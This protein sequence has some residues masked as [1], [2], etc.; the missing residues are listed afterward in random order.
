M[1]NSLILFGQQCLIQGRAVGLIYSWLL[2]AGGLI[3]V[4]IHS[5]FLW[6]GD[7]AFRL[8]VSLGLLVATFIVSMA[9]ATGLLLWHRNPVQ[10]GKQ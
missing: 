5:Y 1:R 8:P 9:Q 3:A 10:I 2:V 6:Q 4:S 7:D